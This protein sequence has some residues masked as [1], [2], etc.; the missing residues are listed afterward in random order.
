MKY[1]HG[2]ENWSCSAFTC[3]I[4]KYRKSLAYFSNVLTRK[5]K[6]TPAEEKILPKCARWKGEKEKL[7]HTALSSQSDP[8]HIAWG[9]RSQAKHPQRNTFYTPECLPGWQ[10]RRHRYIASRKPDEAVRPKSCLCSLNYLTRR[11]LT[12]IFLLRTVSRS[13]KRIS[14]L[15]QVMI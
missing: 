10:V 3:N 8:Q 1:L 11:L 4:W 14:L 2:I 6:W 9:P 7:K 5:P 13:M 12:G 15:R